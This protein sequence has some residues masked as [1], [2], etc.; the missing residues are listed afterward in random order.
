MS[1]SRVLK[2]VWILF[3]LTM[4]VLIHFF[5][6]NEFLE[7]VTQFQEE[8]SEA[9]LWRNH[10]SVHHSDSTEQVRL[11]SQAIFWYCRPLE[12]RLDLWLFFNH[13]PAHQRDRNILYS[14]K[15]R[16]SFPSGQLV[17]NKSLNSLRQPP[18]LWLH[19]QVSF[20]SILSLHYSK[21]IQ[22]LVA[23]LP[24]RLISLYLWSSSLDCI[25]RWRG[26][27][28][29]FDWIARRFP[30]LFESS[31]SLFLSSHRAL[32]FLLWHHPWIHAQ[33][34]P[35]ELFAISVVHA[36]RLSEKPLRPQT[37]PLRWEVLQPWICLQHQHLSMRTCRLSYLSGVC[38]EE[39][40]EGRLDELVFK[41]LNF[42]VK[43]H[44]VLIL[45]DTRVSF[46]VVAWA[47]CVH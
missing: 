28:P 35:E 20:Q 43:S 40:K 12:T 32:P 45:I 14:L 18:S 34:Q 22:L 26:V 7:E 15:S 39:G 24:I 25:E 47:C 31:H 37:N 1:R 8:Q 42:A 38:H 41:R 2:R 33:D 36:Y 44:N 21:P 11:Y 46:V 29:K 17:L 23:P 16:V 6:I 3:S 10:A 9:L 4:G 19:P 27:Y 13:L 30:D 5:Q